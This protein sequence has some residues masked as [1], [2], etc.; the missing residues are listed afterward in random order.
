MTAPV[1]EKVYTVTDASDKTYYYGDISLLDSSIASASQQIDVYLTPISTG[2]QRLLVHSTDYDFTSNANNVTL[3]GSVAT[4][5][6]VGDVVVIERS[7]QAS[8]LYTT[9]IGLNNL[10]SVNVQNAMDQLLHLI[11]ENSTTGSNALTKSIDKTN[12]QGQGLRSTNCSAATTGSGWTTLA[13]VNALIAGGE[14]ATTADQNYKEY[15]GDG[16]TTTFPLPDFPLSDVDPRKLYAIIDGVVQNPDDIDNTQVNDYNFTLVGSTPTVEFATAPA[17]GT[18]IVFRNLSGQV[19]SAIDSNTVDGDVIID[20]TLDVNA[21][22]TTAG[23]ANRFISF[24]TSG[25]ASINVLAASQMSDL[26]ST[27]QAYSLDQFANAAADVD[28]GSNN[29]L[30]VATGTASTHG[31]NKGQMDAAIAAASPSAT[32]Y[33]FARTIGA[34]ATEVVDVGFAA[35]D[36]GFFRGAISGAGVL[37]GTPTLYGGETVIRYSI[38]GTNL[39]ITSSH[40]APLHI[41]VTVTSN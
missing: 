24:D 39:T 21:L 15:T 13:Q 30:N 7:T 9:F 22:D 34:G 14:V 19:Q 10:R 27:V 11:Q 35:T 40:G 25:V 12:W 37:T 3:L 4:N 29:L 20:G 31:V 28:F 36:I 18:T 38:S 41:F 1:T 33:T 6:A 26:S 8:S 32:T 5:L 23:S 17:N 2:I 16:S